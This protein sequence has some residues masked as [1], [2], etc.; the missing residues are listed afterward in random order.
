L[1]DTGR[2]SLLRLKRRGISS[3][4]FSQTENFPGLNSCQSEISVEFSVEIFELL[5]INFFAVD[6]LR[7]NRI[8]RLLDSG[9]IED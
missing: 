1:K 5:F 9:G 4:D 2:P 7:A 6:F 3:W 8:R